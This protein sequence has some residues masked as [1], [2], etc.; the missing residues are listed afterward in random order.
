MLA[1]AEP[2]RQGRKTKRSPERL[3]GWLRWRFSVAPNAIWI[4]F[5]ADAIARSLGCS[6]RTIRR[7]K[8]YLMQHSER[9]GFAFTTCLDPKPSNGWMV[10]VAPT[11]RLLYDRLPLLFSKNGRCR[12]MKTWIR[13]ATL[14]REGRFN[15]KGDPIRPFS[16]EDSHEPD[17][18]GGS[19]APDLDGQTN[20]DGKT[21][22]QHDSEIVT[23]ATIRPAHSMAA[24]SI[25]R[26][27]PCSGW[28]RTP[29]GGEGLSQAPRIRPPNH[30]K[31]PKNHPP[32]RREAY[33]HAL[34]RTLQR[35]HWDN[36][37][38]RYSHSS[39]VSVV[40]N[41]ISNG[42]RASTLL[43]LYSQALHR[44]HAD[45]TDAG[46]VA[47]QPSLTTHQAGTFSFVYKALGFERVDIGER[48]T[49]FLIHDEL[50]HQQNQYWTTRYY[51]TKKAL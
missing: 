23:C 30:T 35:M 22:L 11:N 4:V 44:S 29:F 34:A 51:E 16:L 19:P 12:R 41:L 15:D 45:A 31:T 38:V 13:A 2:T 37:K 3:A 26:S 40:R 39:T 32:E 14:L 47:G 48:Y 24:D 1:L 21:A 5:D 50:L 7:A 28:W 17:E 27:A 8:A 33:F 10:L 6:V 42:C 46:L 49:F 20:Q 18:Q 9:Y 25:N 36:C 43:A